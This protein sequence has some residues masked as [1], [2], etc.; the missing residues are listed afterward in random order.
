MKKG[1][2]LFGFLLFTFPFGFSQTFNKEKLNEYFQA[3]KDHDKFMGSVAILKEGNIIYQKAIGFSDVE[4]KKKNDIQ[5]KF[6]IGSISKT[7]TAAMIFKA[8]EEGKLKL[9]QNIDSYFPTIKDAKIITVANLLNHRSGI[10]SFTDDE[11]YLEYNTNPH[12]EVEMIA[13][14]SDGGSDFPPD[15]KGEY[16]NSNYVL[17]SYILQNTYGKPYGELLKEKITVPLELKDTYFGGAINLANNE[18]NSYEFMGKWEKESET[19][20]SIPMG[21]GGIV[22]TPTDLLMFMDGLFKGEII[23]KESLDIMKT[24]TDDYGSGLFQFPFYDKTSYGHTGGIDGFTSVVGYFPK[25]DIGFA[26]TSNGRNFNTNDISIVLLSSVFDKAFEIP[27]F[28]TVELISEDLDK[29]LGTYSTPK[30]PLKI[31]FSKKGN[32]LIAQ[33]TGQ[34]EIELVAAE[35]NLFKFDPAGATFQFFPD[36]NQM[37]FKQSGMVFMLDK[38]E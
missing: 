30:F 10:H 31:T 24:I 12:S 11:N 23:S 14:I 37:E 7:F 1:I 17:L 18:S 13:M 2:L 26:I 9:T 38:E 8:V 28:K 5:T 6:R 20:S 15:S 21:A 29:F 4:T 22:S 34:P 16:S 27:S 36:K 35:D 19:D 33:A 32:T 3:L 25:E